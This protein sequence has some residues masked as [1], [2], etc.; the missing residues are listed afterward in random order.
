MLDTRLRGYDTVF[1]YGHFPSKEE[2]D[3]RERRVDFDELQMLL[4][5]GF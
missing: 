3:M 1:E 2:T 4:N 5:M